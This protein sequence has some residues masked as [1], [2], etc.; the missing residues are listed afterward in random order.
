VTPPSLLNESRIVMKKIDL[1]IHTVS[2]VSDSDFEFSIGTIRRYVSEAELDAIALTNHNVFDSSQFI[3]I[4]Q[5]VDCQVF[6]GIEVDLQSGHLLLIASGDNLADFDSKCK[7]VSAEI[8]TET[9]SISTGKLN[10][11]F[12]NLSSY[13]LIPHYRKSP[14]VTGSEY[15]DLISYFSAGEVDSAKKFVREMKRS[16]GLCPV[17]FSDSR[18]AANIGKLP[19]R[20]T[21]IDCGDVNLTA[22]KATLKD[23]SK[24]FLSMSDG[25]ELFQVFEDGQHMSTGLNVVYGDR[26][27]GKTV[28]LNK[29]SESLGSVKYIRQFELVQS[30][31]KEDEKQFNAEVQKRRSAFVDDY[32]S[33]FRVLVGD[34]SKV[35]IDVDEKNVEKYIETLLKSA[36]EADRE[37]SYSKVILYKETEYTIGSNK[38][39]KD[40]IASVINLIENVDFRRVV[41]SHLSINSLRSLAIDLIR[42]LWSK[43]DQDRNRKYVN[44]MV[45]DVK[46]RLQVRTAATRIETTDLYDYALNKR[47]INR[48]NEIA[49]AL[50]S[51]MTIFDEPV[52]GFRVVAQKGPYSQA[53]ELNEVIRSHAPFKDALRSYGNPYEFLCKVKKIEKVQES[54]IHRLFAK[55]TYRIL[56]ESGSDVSGGERSEF[57]LLRAIKDA[58][59]FDALLIDEPESSFDNRF[60]NCNVNDIIKSISR[61]MPVVVVTHN[62]SVGASI[63]PDYLI[64]AEKKREHDSDV[65]RLYSGYPTDKRLKCIDGAEVVTYDIFLNALEAG[66]DAYNHRREIYETVKD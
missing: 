25:N 29:M 32:L 51:P 10:E 23:K 48:F 33:N 62:N 43:S 3:Q 11:I 20:Q 18:M 13:L 42:R 15:A 61:E 41:E 63:H 58:Q 27:S 16:E 6:P 24:V 66:S 36:D 2:T 31:D 35:E 52:Q 59:M 1:H 19:T 57:R 26:S 7:R 34:I 64:Y 47:K 49:A 37:D 22:I 53:S 28:T 45:K 40:L 50:Q 4:Q 9:D 14:P 55:I 46:D 65:Y 30:S 54:E 8:V 5:E 39:L 56:N 21:Y 38:G 17:L 12:G 60:L 44:S